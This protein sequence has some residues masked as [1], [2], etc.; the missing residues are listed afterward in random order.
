LFQSLVKTKAE[1]RNCL[2][3]LVVGT[4]LSLTYLDYLRDVC[5]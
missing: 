2:R 1:G 5:V 4:S 3:E